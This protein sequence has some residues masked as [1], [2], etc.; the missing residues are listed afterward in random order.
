MLKVGL[1]HVPALPV[2]RG[3]KIMRWEVYVLANC[4]AFCAMLWK[5]QAHEWRGLQA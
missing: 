1:A 5:C 3:R 4:T 2:Q